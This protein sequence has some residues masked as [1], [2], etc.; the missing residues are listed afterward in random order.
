M[1]VGWMYG[2]RWVVGWTD[3]D[4]CLGVYGWMDACLGGWMMLGLVYGDG[5]AAG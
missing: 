4:G 3:D 2:Y 1:M 5:R